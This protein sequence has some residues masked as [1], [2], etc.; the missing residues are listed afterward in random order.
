[1][2]K[3]V[4]TLVS[5]LERPL[6]TPRTRTLRANHHPLNPN[7]KPL[8]P[9]PKLAGGH[10]PLPNPTPKAQLYPLPLSTQADIDRE[11]HA[12][13]ERIKNTVAC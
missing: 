4:S 2:S 9:T 11:N 12:M 13:R 5:R 6:R 3:S 7:P 10:C 8:T 1:M